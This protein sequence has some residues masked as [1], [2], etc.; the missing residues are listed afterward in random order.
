[1][2]ALLGLGFPAKAAEQAVDAVLAENG[3]T[4][5]SAALRAALSH[6]GRSR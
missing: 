5:A 4:T 1:V 6:L 3:G 2:E